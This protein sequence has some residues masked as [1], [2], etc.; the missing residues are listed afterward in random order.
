MSWHGALTF[1]DAG[2]DMRNQTAHLSVNVAVLSDEELV[3]GLTANDKDTYLV[4]ELWRRTNTAIAK[5]AK[6]ACSKV[7]IDLAMDDALSEAYVA[8]W[9]ALPRFDAN[10]GA[11]LKTYL[12]NKVKYH[13]LQLNRQGKI[14]AGRHVSYR[15]EY[16]EYDDGASCY[17]A[18]YDELYRA[19]SERC[20]SE[21]RE[22]EVAQ[23]IEQ[24]LA[25][26][27]EPR[28]REC[29]K[30]LWQAYVKGEPKPVQ[31]AAAWLRCSRQQVYNILKQIRASVPANL[32]KKVKEIL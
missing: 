19:T 18:E 30:Y 6:N 22:V 12:G 7:D 2:V 8:A 9:K 3:R 31:Y 23:A 27:T 21:K 4:D 28:H 17:G 11:S 29:L 25:L 1:K 16:E 10:K 14:H 20:H 13:I 32:A 26:V 24:V 5:A 15:E